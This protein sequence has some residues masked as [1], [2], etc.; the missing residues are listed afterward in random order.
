MAPPSGYRQISQGSSINAPMAS[1]RRLYKIN[2]KTGKY[3]VDK[4]GNPI[5]WDG[6]VVDARELVKQREYTATSPARAKLNA[7]LTDEEG[8]NPDQILVEDDVDSIIPDIAQANLDAMDLDSLRVLGKRHSIPG[9]ATMER[10][11]ILGALK[12][13]LAI[14]TQK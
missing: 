4:H 10:D 7:A 14:D 2:P 9:Y 8:I 6:F 12:D 1:K 5:V 13:L 11:S 3:V